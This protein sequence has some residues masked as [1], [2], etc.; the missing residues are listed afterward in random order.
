MILIL[1]L[2][3]RELQSVSRLTARA[4]SLPLRSSF[5]QITLSISAAFRDFKFFS[6][7]TTINRN[8]SRNSA[9]S[10][11]FYVEQL[12]PDTIPIRNN[13]PVILNSTQLSEAMD[14]ETITISSVTSPEPQLVTLDSDSNEVIFPPAFGA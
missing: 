9:N 1:L 13:T 6:L 14:P 7:F 5:F 3:P 2:K 11:V 8:P 10:D 4:A 12:S